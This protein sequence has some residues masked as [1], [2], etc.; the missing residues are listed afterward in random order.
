M[1]Y[2]YIVTLVLVLSGC[3]CLEKEYVRIKDSEVL[4]DKV[5]IEVQKGSDSASADGNEG[6]A[7][8]PIHLP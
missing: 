6:N 7:S 5:I 1:R 3:A 2:F 4:V 8:L